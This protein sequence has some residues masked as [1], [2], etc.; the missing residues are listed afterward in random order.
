VRYS[1]LLWAALGGY[2]F[3]GDLPDALTVVGAALVVVAGVGSLRTPRAAAEPA[4]STS[5]APQRKASARQ[6]LF[7]RA[8]AQLDDLDA[9]V[10]Y[11]EEEEPDE[12]AECEQAVAE[13][14]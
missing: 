9:P 13:R 3:F 8:W 14:L 7:N 6:H 2:F 10:E 11:V 1:L 12:G 4:A 5:T